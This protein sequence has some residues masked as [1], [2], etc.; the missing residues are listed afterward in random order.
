MGMLPGHRQDQE[1]DRPPANLDDK[2]LKRQ[3]AIIQS[4]TAG[5]RAAAPMCSRRSRKKRVAGRLRHPRFEEV[6]K[7][8][9]MHRGMAGP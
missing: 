6:N 1:P 3:V 7:L 5:E 8:L 2:L 4:M 9:K